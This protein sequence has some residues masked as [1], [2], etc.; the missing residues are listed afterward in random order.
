MDYE[1]KSACESCIICM[2]FAASPRAF[3]RDGVQFCELVATFG[4]HG[5][6]NYKHDHW[7]SALTVFL[8]FLKFTFF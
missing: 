4:K 5:K 6:K 1:S 7:S 8:Q 3:T 2:C